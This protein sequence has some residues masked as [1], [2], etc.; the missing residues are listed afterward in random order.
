M[1]VLPSTARKPMKTVLIL[2]DEDL[3]RNLLGDGLEDLDG[4][5]VKR[6]ATVD[7]ADRLLAE[8]T[9]DVLVLDMVMGSD[10]LQV[11]EWV[12]RGQQGGKLGNLPIVFVTAFSADLAELAKAIPRSQLL[13]KPFTFKEIREAIGRALS[14]GDA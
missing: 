6:A 2:E 12:R 5:V 1:I 13:G 7:E 9:P 10:H 14:E 11:I 4:F 8:F 3:H